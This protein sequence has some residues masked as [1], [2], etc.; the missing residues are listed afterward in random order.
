MELHGLR[1]A[2]VGYMDVYDMYPMD[3]EEF[4]WANGV[5]EKI[6]KTLK[7]CFEERRP[8]DPFIHDQMLKLFHL[9]MIVGG[10]P[11]AINAYLRENNLEDVS[12]T[13]KNILRLYQQDFVKYDE[14][15]SL[16]I[17][18]LFESIPDRLMRKEIP[19]EENFEKSFRWLKDAGIVLPANNVEKAELPLRLNQKKNDFIMYLGDVG[20]LTSC[21]SNTV[22]MEILQQKPVH[23]EILQNAVAQELSEKGFR[24]YFCRN[25]NL[26]FLIEKDGK[27]VAI[28]VFSGKVPSVEMP[29]ETVDQEYILSTENVSANGKTIYLPLYMILFLEETPL[30]D[31]I[32]TIDIAKLNRVV[33]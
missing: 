24:L 26:D 23:T 33:E 27:P 3:L 17:R 32:Y 16:D 31:P 1:S 10:E 15:Y 4:L 18:E 7:T 14:Q 21:F 9:Y 30:M 12:E 28:R 2:P 20:L 5:S 19:A 6:I 25:R 11:E 22:K 29:P 13:Q 8:V